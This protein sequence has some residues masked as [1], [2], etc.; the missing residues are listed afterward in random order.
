VGTVNFKD[1]NWLNAGEY[2]VFV[3][4]VACNGAVSPNSN[5]ETITA[6][7]P[8]C[9]EGEDNAPETMTGSGAASIALYPNPA[10][11][12]FFVDIARSAKGEAAVQIELVNALGQ[13]VQTDLGGAFGFY[14]RLCRW[15]HF[16]GIGTRVVLVRCRRDLVWAW[17]VWWPGCVSS[18]T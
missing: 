18:L 13:V 12:D 8:G 3:R 17:C 14:K 11:G 10:S 1:V 4:S 9:R 16:N 7:G 6:S 15:K 5:V 2:S